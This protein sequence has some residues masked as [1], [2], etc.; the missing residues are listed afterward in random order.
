MPCCTLRS[1]SICQVRRAKDPTLCSSLCDVCPRVVV[2]CCW[3]N[4]LTPS[5]SMPTNERFRWTQLSAK[6]RQP[7]CHTA[8]NFDLPQHHTDM[9]NDPKWWPCAAP[10]RI[11]R[12]ATNKQ[13]FSL[14][15]TI[16]ASCRVS[17]GWY[18]SLTHGCVVRQTQSLSPT[19]QLYCSHRP[20]KAVHECSPPN[21][22]QL[23]MDFCLCQNVCCLLGTKLCLM[24]GIFTN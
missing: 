11:L 1:N 17:K 24:K 20:N 23:L 22:N 18:S 12:F 14:K 13:K 4:P 15:G 9:G 16:E 3:G 7:V 19:L 8:V 21:S 5:G 2:C 10:T 6:C